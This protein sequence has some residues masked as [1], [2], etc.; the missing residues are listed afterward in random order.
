MTAVMV[1]YGMG[2]VVGVVLGAV[3]F[4]AWL[5]GYLLWDGLQGGD[6]IKATVAATG[7]VAIWLV[8]LARLK[9]RRG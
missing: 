2:V 5:A 8:L 4:L 6:L 1:S 3:T 9:G 7:F